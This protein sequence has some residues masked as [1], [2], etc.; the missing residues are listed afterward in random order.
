MC[1]LMRM[2]SN[3]R[4][5]HACIYC[6]FLIEAA[7]TRTKRTNTVSVKLQSNYC[8]RGAMQ[9]PLVVVIVGYFI[10]NHN[11]TP[12]STQKTAGLKIRKQRQNVIR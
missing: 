1:A 9:L 8:L 2:F 4:L 11:I 12:S 10:F 5:Y 7:N 6:L 3:V